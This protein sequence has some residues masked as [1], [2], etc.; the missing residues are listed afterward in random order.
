MLGRQQGYSHP[1][2][3]VC[4]R[5]AA[6]HP[7]SMTP[8]M[9]LLE[10]VSGK[11]CSPTGDAASSG[12]DMADLPRRCL[13]SN[14]QS[15]CRARATHAGTLTGSKR[16]KLANVG[17]CGVELLHPAREMGGWTEASM[18]ARH[19]PPTWQEWTTPGDTPAACAVCVA[20]S[21]AIRQNSYTQKQSRPQAF[22]GCL[23]SLQ[24]ECSRLHPAPCLLDRRTA[25]S[26]RG[27]G[28]A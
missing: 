20:S 18:G 26:R 28:S 19:A 7:P 14:H 13:F 2:L 8:Y 24:Q 21:A 6:S 11:C 9:G 1:W 12:R 4:R 3:V 27:A 17:A 15:N 10:H 16:A 22:T 5:D 23:S 25:I